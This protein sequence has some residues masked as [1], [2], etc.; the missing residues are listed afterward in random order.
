MGRV[1]TGVAR[2]IMK[3]HSSM[4]GVAACGVCGINEHVQHL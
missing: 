2:G 1:I 3:I 4:G